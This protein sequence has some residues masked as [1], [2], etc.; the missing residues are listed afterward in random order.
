MRELI[1]AVLVRA[2]REVVTVAGPRAAL[3]AL[4]LQPAIALLLVD[5]VMP[6]MDGYELVAEARKISPAV[7]VLF[8]SAFAPDPARHPSTD[9]FLGKPFTGESLTGQVTKALASSH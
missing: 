3:A 7:K 9:G 8:I 2:G 5:I 1:K 4:K 6:E